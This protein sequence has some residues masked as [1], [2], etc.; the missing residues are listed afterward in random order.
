MPTFQSADPAVP[1]VDG[2]HSTSG[3]ALT[4]NSVSGMGVH[5]VNDAPRGASIKPNFGCGVWG[6]ST[7][8]YGVWGSSDNASGVVGESLNNIGVNG[9]SAN[10]VGVMA[11]STGGN[12]MYA[13]AA[14]RPFLGTGPTYVGYGLFSVLTA[15]PDAVF[16][17]ENA[18][19]GVAGVSTTNIGVLGVS[20]TQPGVEGH[21]AGIGVS[22]KGST[23]I[24]GVGETGLQG[25][26]SKSG[27]AG[28]YFNPND[29]GVAFGFIGGRDPVFNQL[30]GVYGEG[31]DSGV[32]GNSD[33]AGG[34]GLHGRSGGDGGF[35]VRGEI[36]NGVAA[37]Q[38]QSF[39]TGLAG[40]FIGGVRVRGDLEVSGDIRLINADCAEHFSV[41][42]ERPV[43]AGTV[44]V[45]GRG[46]LVF[47]SRVAYDNRVAGIVSGAGSFKPGLVLDAAPCDRQR[48]PLA[49]MGKVYCKEDASEV[50][51]E[52]GD[53][54]T[55]TATEGFAM[56][57]VDH[58][59]AFGAV[60]GKALEPL[61]HGRALIPVL[62][63]LQ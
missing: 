1:A 48:Q 29:L 40:Q 21:S 54:L 20:A 28:S 18:G 55:T 12:A 38:G 57:A 11:R 27:V 39:G 14:G 52:I 16:A 15:S 51:V 36:G 24:F 56:K 9:Q 5:G 42:T 8:G 34:T 7:N 23:G 59:R 33:A 46:G 30:A 53:L 45:L 47:P 44:M 35:G 58:E 50:P 43:D 19:A 49:L 37:V 2:E 6:E 31:N 25:M 22:G 63:A 13:L 62:V 60:I 17:F 61:A 3:T 4:G 41:G 32:F 26:G 10:N